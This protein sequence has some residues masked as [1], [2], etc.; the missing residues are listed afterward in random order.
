[1]SVTAPEWLAQH[2]G[3]LL[4]SRDGGSWLVFFGEE[5]EYVLMPTPA[6]GR[7]ACRISQTING[8]RLDGSDV[9]A[10]PEDAF[11]GGLETLRQALGW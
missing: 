10:T 3:R 9:Y 11:R 8:R 7:Y 5:P 2:G 6:C 1:M 4:A